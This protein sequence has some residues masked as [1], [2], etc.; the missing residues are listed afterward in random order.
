MNTSELKL[1]ESYYLAS[2]IEIKTD[3][4]GIGLAF[5]KGTKVIF[6]SKTRETEGRT[7]AFLVAMSG[8]VLTLTEDGVA[9]YINDFM[10]NAEVM[11]V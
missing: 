9:K 1:N 8:L 3:K 6:R 5:K 4:K 2:D 10:V 11:G 7:Y